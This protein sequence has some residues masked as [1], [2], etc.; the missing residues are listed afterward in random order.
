[1]KKAFLILLISAQLCAQDKYV[2]P[3]GSDSNQGT[4]QQPY[5]TIKKGLQNANGTVF[6]LEGAYTEDFDTRDVPVGRSVV[7][8]ANP[9]ATVSI[10]GLMTL[11]GVVTP[12]P[13]PAGPQVSVTVTQV[14]PGAL[15]S[16]TVANGPGNRTDWLGVYA[17]GA[18]AYSYQAWAYLNGQTS[19]P[20]SG[21]KSAT[22]SL[23]MPTR[24]G[25]YEL[26]LY[27]NNG[28]SPLLSTSATI[29]VQ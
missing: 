28:F 14:A 21:L 8:Q 12:P 25:T 2:S 13:P 26:R 27:P 16:I 7:I 11:V 20:A 5:K 18:S 22:V 17:V 4:L 24:A 23:R 29:R 19:P 6:L 10:R 15:V 9:G 3:T 1:M